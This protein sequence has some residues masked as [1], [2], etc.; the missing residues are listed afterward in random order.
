MSIKLLIADDE[1]AF[2]EYMATL[3][4]AQGFR[5]AA[6]ADGAEALQ[7]FSTVQPDLVL[8]DVEM[9]EMTGFEVLEHLQ[10]DPALR[11]DRRPQ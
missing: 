6:A 10:A 1:P 7:Q 8:L 2:R 5:V 9:P 11:L 3:L 4:R